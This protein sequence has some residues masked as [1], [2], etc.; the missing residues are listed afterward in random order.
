MTAA[1]LSLR[2]EKNL[3]DPTFYRHTTADE[4]KERP[5]NRNDHRARGGPDL[6][7]IWCG[8]SPIH[9][10]PEQQL[11]GQDLYLGAEIASFLQ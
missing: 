11:M 2:Q 5:Q 7:Y 10:D 6:S 8:G 3:K 4:D 9:D 1:A